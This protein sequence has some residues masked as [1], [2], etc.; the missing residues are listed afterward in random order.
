MNPAPPVTR[1]FNYRLPFSSLPV[2]LM[3]LILNKFRCIDREMQPD[4]NKNQAKPNRSLL[5]RRAGD[6]ISER[7]NRN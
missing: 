3:R 4:W 7:C 1:T 6:L 5:E 2:N